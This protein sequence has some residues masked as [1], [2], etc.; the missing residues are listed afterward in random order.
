MI[1][2]KR[3]HG[4]SIWALEAVPGAISLYDPH[5]ALQSGAMVL[6]VV[7]NEVSG[8]DPAVTWAAERVIMLPMLG[9]KESLNVSIAAGVAIYNLCHGVKIIQPDAAGGK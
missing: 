1:N 2:E 3:K 5:L 6:L 4:F 8:V 9:A 7:G